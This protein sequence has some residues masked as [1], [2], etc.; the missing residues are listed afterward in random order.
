[1][2]PR[3]IAEQIAGAIVEDALVGT[4]AAL[5]YGTDY[6]ESALRDYGEKCRAEERERCKEVASEWH[7]TARQ[8]AKLELCYPGRERLIPGISRGIDVACEQI[9]IAISN[10][11]NKNPSP[12][13]EPT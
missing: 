9:A 5:N 11:G 13:N 8:A 12:A 1:M 10:L 7:P 2:T 3:E 4:P 6:I